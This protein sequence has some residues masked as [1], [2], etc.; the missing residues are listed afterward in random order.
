MAPIV[1][2]LGTLWGPLLGAVVVHLLAEPTNLVTGD[3]PGL[4]LMIYGACWCWSSLSRRAAAR[5][6]SDCANR[7]RAGARD[8]GAAHG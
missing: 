2:G 6:P 5:L 8:R 4:D 3:A 7:A 1:G